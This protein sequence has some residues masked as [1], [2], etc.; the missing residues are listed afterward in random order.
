[1]KNLATKSV[2]VLLGLVSVILCGIIFF[3]FNYIKNKS[4]ST[5]D[6]IRKVEESSNNSILVQSINSTGSNSANELDKLENLALSQEKLVNF[7][8]TLEGLGRSMNLNINIVSVDSEPGKSVDNPDK[9]HFRIEASGSWSGT[10]QFLHALESL[11]YR[12]MIN[13][14][15][16]TILNGSENLS[17]SSTTTAQK[18]SWKLS[19]DLS[20]YSFK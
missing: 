2:I 14:S 7:I 3:G 9:I 19:T 15:N 17:S 4:I 16:L 1:M 6:T 18:R 11:P 20:V 12:T 5:S 10:M 13:N 8:E